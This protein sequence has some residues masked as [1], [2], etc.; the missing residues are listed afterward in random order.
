MSTDSA[1]KPQTPE[2]KSARYKPPLAKKDVNAKKPALAV[3]PQ[4]LAVARSD[5][6]RE[7]GLTSAD[8]RKS[9]GENTEKLAH[10]SRTPS[11]T[12]SLKEAPIPTTPE[13]SR[14][15][16]NLRKTPTE[17]DPLPERKLSVGSHSS[18]GVLSV[19]QEPPESFEDSSLENV[20]GRLE[21]LS[22]SSKD[23]SA[24][25]NDV[26]SASSPSEGITDAFQRKSS[27]LRLRP[28]LRP[29]VIPT[30][31]SFGRLDDAKL[32][33]NEDRSKSLSFSKL[34]SPASTE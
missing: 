28:V 6:S 15:C 13:L 11:P 22:I 1:A 20:D 2:T 25:N 12:K 4:F 32:L 24:N 33:H 19:V 9:G 30:S 8:G 7:G 27:S 26:S 23:S 5:S 29:S 10:L 17:A 21:K 31:G 14:I 16:T 18:G 3:K 34:S